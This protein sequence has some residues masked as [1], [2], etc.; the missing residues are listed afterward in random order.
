MFVCLF[1][2]NAKTTARIDPKCSG[3]TKNNPE[4]VL[5]C[6]KSTVLVFSERYRT[7]FGFSFAADRHFNLSSTSGSYLLYEHCKSKCNY[8]SACV[9]YKLS[10]I[11]K[12]LHMRACLASSINIYVYMHACFARNCPGALSHCGQGH[13]LTSVAQLSV[14]TSAFDKTLASEQFHQNAVDGAP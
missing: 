11:D 1:A 9:L 5:C 13:A 8:A 14:I 7:I 10:C 4:S 2:V 3:I 12:F 6:L